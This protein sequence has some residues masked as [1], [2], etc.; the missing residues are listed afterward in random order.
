MNR[1]G[2][3]WFCAFFGIPGLRE[4][5]LVLLVA[6]VLYGR[7]GLYV[8]RTLG[9][10][11]STT[12]RRPAGAGVQARMRMKTKSQAEPTIS[13]RLVRWLERD[14]LFWFLA[15]LAASAIVAWVVTRTL[16]VAGPERSHLH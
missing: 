2:V 1:A 13:P 11:S 15:I 16:I 8:A 7:R 14:R 6:L 12:R 3:P 10:L 5:I 9:S 4:L